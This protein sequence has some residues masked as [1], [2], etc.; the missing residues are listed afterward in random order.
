MNQN[1]CSTCGNDH[2]ESIYLPDCQGCIND[3]Y[4]L[5]NR[6]QNR[7]ASTPFNESEG[8]ATAS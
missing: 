5:M 8:G 7:I 2:S 1:F 3:L 6:S 4:D